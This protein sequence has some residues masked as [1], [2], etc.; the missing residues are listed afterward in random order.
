MRSGTTTAGTKSK[1]K[2]PEGNNNKENDRNIHTEERQRAHRTT[3]CSQSA[4]QTAWLRDYD[5]GE[6]I[7]PQHRRDEPS[8]L[9]NILKGHAAGFRETRDSF[10]NSNAQNPLSSDPPTMTSSTANCPF[11]VR[12]PEHI[13]VGPC[14]YY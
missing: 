10:I 9:I 13:R 2:K 6:R 1:R 5:E 4:R 8:V 3:D 12:P 11:P 14:I 7:R